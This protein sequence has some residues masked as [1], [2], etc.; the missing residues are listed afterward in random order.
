MGDPELIFVPIILAI[1]LLSGEMTYSFLCAFLPTNRT[2]YNDYIN[3]N[4]DGDVH[5]CVYNYFY[6]ST[7]DPK[8]FKIELRI[9]LSN[10]PPKVQFTIELD[11]ITA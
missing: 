11:I 2:F 9:I 7:K 6:T 4:S 1:I 8:N 3:S 10:H 5:P